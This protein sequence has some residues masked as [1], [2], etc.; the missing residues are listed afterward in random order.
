MRR[1]SLKIRF[2]AGAE[3]EEDGDDSQL[4]LY[5]S[6]CQAVD[7]SKGDEHKWKAGA[8]LA[9]EGISS[10]GWHSTAKWCLNALHSICYLHITNTSASGGVLGSC[11]H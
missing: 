8:P 7:M 10:D 1:Y 2:W 5:T 11:C 4:L 6:V 3:L 9:V